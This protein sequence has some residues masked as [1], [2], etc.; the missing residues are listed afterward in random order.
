MATPEGPRVHFAIWQDHSPL[1]ACEWAFGPL[2][3]T[4]PRRCSTSWT[5]VDCHACKKVVTEHARKLEP[6][7]TLSR[8]ADRFLARA[9]L[10]YTGTTVEK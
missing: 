9:F 4:E 5:L 8:T 1:Y 3:P 2:E 10:S 6:E 7:A